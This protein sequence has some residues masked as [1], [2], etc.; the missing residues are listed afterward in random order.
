[1]QLQHSLPMLRLTLLRYVTLICYAMLR[2]VTLERPKSSHHD[3]EITDMSQNTK[4]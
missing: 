4:R 1:M 2:Y 3:I